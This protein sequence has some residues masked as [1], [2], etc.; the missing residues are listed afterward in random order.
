[1]TL[2]DLTELEERLVAPRVPFMQIRELGYQGQLQLKGS[3]VN[4]ENNLDKIAKAIPRTMDDTSTVQVK[5]MRRQIYRRPVYHAN[6]RPYV[7][8]NA[9]KALVETPLFKKHNIVLSQEWENSEPGKQHFFN[10][11]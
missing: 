1:M 11:L 7:V 5:F 9:A 6:I 4:V 10:L 8:R 2:Q 3:I